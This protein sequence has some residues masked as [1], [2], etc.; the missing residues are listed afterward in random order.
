MLKVHI[1]GDGI[2]ARAG[3][4][5]H[6]LP[7]RPSQ[8]CRTLD[9][10]QP[11]AVGRVGQ[12]DGLASGRK[13]GHICHLEMA[14]FLN[15][16]QLCVGVGQ[17]DGGR[18]DVIAERLKSHV[19]LG[20]CQSLLPLLGPDRGRHKAVPLGGEA[21]FQAGGDVH[22]FLGGLDQQRAAAAE[23]V[24]HDAVAAHPPQIGNGCRQRLAEGGFHRVAA[25][26]ALVQTVAGGVQHDL[27][28][29][30][31][32]HKA[33]LVLRASLGQNRGLVFEHQ[34]L[35][36]GLLD[37]ALAGR[38]AGQL[39]VQGRTGDR[40]RRIRRKQLFPRDGIHAVEQLVEGGSRVGVEQ[41]H[42]PLDG[43]QVQVCGGDHLRTA[44]EGQPAV[45]DPDI[46]GTDPAQLKVGGGFAPE[47]AGGDQFKF[48]GHLVFLSCGVG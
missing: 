2:H 47:K 29:V 41:Q 45:T 3:V 42:H 19:Q 17:C 37:D 48:C 34:P 18:V 40:E 14:A 16:G 7:Q 5:L 25:V 44:L 11:L 27:A 23:G 46:L 26:A 4:G 1:G 10:A 38:H 13:I 21:A 12:D 31:P 20:L 15:T 28:D 36:D 8:F 24:F 43:A 6:L 33:D 39:A 22:G 30:L 32:Q 35:D 9:D